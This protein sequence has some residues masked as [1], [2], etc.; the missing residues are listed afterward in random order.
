MHIK[1]ELGNIGEQIAVEYL[2][3]NKYHC[4]DKLQHPTYIPY[5]LVLDNLQH[6]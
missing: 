4:F 1:K 3:K 5:F 6:Y 2:S